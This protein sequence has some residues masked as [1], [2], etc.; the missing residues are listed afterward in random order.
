MLILIMNISAQRQFAA[1]KF[2][3]K[4]DVDNGIAHENMSTDHG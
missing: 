4:K 3:K 1:Q 2:G